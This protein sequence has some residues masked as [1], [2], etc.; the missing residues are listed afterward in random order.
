M[1]DL[2]SDKALIWG[3]GYLLVLALTI[4]LEHQLVGRLWRRH[5]LAR[6]ILG[7]STVMGLA[8]P[9]LLADVL[10]WLTWIILMAGFIIA[11]CIVGFSNVWESARR[12]ELK[13]RAIRE[14]WKAGQDK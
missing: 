9:L 5:E 12:E 10:D 6:R 11:G 14:R 13:R 2:V 7:I 1:A 4:G 8:V 3:V